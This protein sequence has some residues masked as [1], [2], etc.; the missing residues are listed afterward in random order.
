MFDIAVDDQIVATQNLTA[1]A[2][3]HFVDLE[4]LNPGEPDARENRGEG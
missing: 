1:I 2:P 3:G 4:Y